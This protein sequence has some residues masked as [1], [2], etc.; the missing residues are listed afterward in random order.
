[1][2]VDEPPADES[3]GLT[4]EERAAKK[5]RKAQATAR[6][7]A[8]NAAYKA[9]K[10]DDALAAYREAA[11]LDPDEIT[12]LINESAVHFETGALDECIAVCQRAIE[13]GREVHAPF[14]NIAK[15]FARIGNAHHK[16]GNLEEAA[17]AYENSL[18]EHR[19]DDV[20]E[21]HK[22]IRAE[23]KK[24]AELAYL[25]PVKAEEA[26]ERGNEA[27]KAGDFPRAMAEYSEAIKRA[28]TNA[29]YWTN[30]ATAAA[31]LMDFQGSM[32]DANHAIKLDPKFGKAYVRLGNAQ[33]AV[34][35]FHK[36]METFK[37]ALEIEPENSEARDGLRRVVMK[38]NDSAAGSAGGKESPEDMERASRA[39]ADPEIQAILRD[40]M[41]K[42]ALDDMQQNPQMLMHIQKS[43]P[44][45]FGK[46]QKLI[47]AGI[48]RFG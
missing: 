45:M 42:Q 40:P 17:A 5:Q 31:K 7:E 33:F 43:D 6:K 30:R 29:K 46:I 14:A 11:S 38:I 39:L 22:K 26:K 20:H 15:A 25:D 32:S 12:Y 44:T 34:K 28:P 2:E 3:D 10:F 4:P 16:K 18:L 24:T 27:F 41:V 19:T 35:E 36:A 48:I 47:A 21:K 23:I 1:M 8:G 9:R 37:K 13:R